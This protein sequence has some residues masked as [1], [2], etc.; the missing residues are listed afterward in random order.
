MYCRCVVNIMYCHA[1]IVQCIVK[2]TRHGMD[3]TCF[4]RNI[5]LIGGGIFMQMDKI[6]NVMWGF[7][8]VQRQ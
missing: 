2:D 4:G 5:T 1:Y 7:F 6:K 8:F 3:L